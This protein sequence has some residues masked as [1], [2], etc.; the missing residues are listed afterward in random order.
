MP[1][2]KCAACRTRLHSPKDPAELVGELC[3]HC[4]AL[5]EPVGELSEIIGFRSI[6]S[7]DRPP[8]A[9]VPGTTAPLPGR[10]DDFVGRRQ[11][12]I[13]RAE[14]DAEH[15]AED[16]SRLLA[17]AVALLPPDPHA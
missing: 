4:G 13:A 11:A 5:L 17:E 15:W 14:L 7:V 6:A 1:H 12:V 3:S 2:V 16:R 9:D 10:P 8:A